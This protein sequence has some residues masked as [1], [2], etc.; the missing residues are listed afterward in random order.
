LSHWPVLAGTRI[1]E[2]AT[3]RCQG[4][5]IVFDRL[6][7]VPPAPIDEFRLASAEEIS[8]AQRL[9]LLP[10]AIEGGPQNEDGSGDRGPQDPRPRAGNGG[11]ALP[12]T[13]ASQDR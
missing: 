4:N 5:M 8:E 2:D 13:N 1:I 9:G 11:T 6:V 12:L 3:A 10:S 7:P